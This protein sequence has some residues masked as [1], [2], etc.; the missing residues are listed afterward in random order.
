VTNSTNI[1]TVNDN[2]KHIFRASKKSI[3]RVLSKAAESAA[4]LRAEI[5]AMCMASLPKIPRK[6]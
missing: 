3:E 4:G 5:D 6:K 1:K 2:N